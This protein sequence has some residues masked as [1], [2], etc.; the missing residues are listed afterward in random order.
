MTF[1]EAVAAST[2]A[3]WPLI[4]LFWIPLH[5][6]PGL[7]KRL[8]LCYYPLI[9]AIWLALAYLMFTKRAHAFLGRFDPPLLIALFGAV[10]FLVGLGLQIA[11]TL[12]L[13]KGI[14][15][16]PHFKTT[17]KDLLVTEG[18]FALSRHPTYLAHTLIFLGAFLL[19]GYWV[20][21]LVAL[22]D[23][24][25]VQLVIIPLE[26]RELLERFGQTYKAYREKTPR[27]LP[28]FRR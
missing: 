15:G 13:G 1:W 6:F 5:L 18:P 26:E 19:T 17:S 22:L 28:R 25:V 27:F 4:P 11:T 9:T 21:G 3:F 24:L 2:M 10:L 8:G 16:L 7:R 12:I 20:V 14:I 23:F